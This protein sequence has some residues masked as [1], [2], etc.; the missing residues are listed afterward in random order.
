M[1]DSSNRFY[2]GTFDSGNRL[3]RFQINPPVEMSTIKTVE[4]YS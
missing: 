3:L 2:L 4:F 1:S